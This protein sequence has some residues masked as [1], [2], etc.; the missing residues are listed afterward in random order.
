MMRLSKI[1]MVA[2]AL[3]SMGG[4]RAGI[5]N[6]DFNSQPPLTSTPLTLSSGGVNATLTS[7]ADPGGF[8]V[9]SP[10]GF[11]S[12]SENVLVSPGGSPELSITF[13]QS[14]S[15]FTADFGTEGSGSLTVTALSGGLSG[16]TVGSSFATGT[17][18]TDPN[19]YPDCFP[20]GTISY[21]GASFDSLILSDA[22]DPG[23]A[24][25]SFSVTTAPNSVPEP[26]TLALLSVGLV[27]LAFAGVR[28]R[29]RA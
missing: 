20:Q 10:L 25:G 13:D 7:S 1:A 19:C 14:L 21:G 28:R 3:V 12:L 24:L 2:A 4:A 17:P 27:A 16:T 6:F 18:G 22:T 5:I 8:F 23:F 29:R 9:I 11:L 15:S 26:D